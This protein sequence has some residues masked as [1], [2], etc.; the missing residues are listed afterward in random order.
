MSIPEYSKMLTGDMVVLLKARLVPKL[1]GKICT[2]SYYGRLAA[3]FLREELRK[4]GKFAR[5]EWTRGGAM[6]SEYIEIP[7]TPQDAANYT[8]GGCGSFIYGSV[9][10][11]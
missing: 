6:F 9:S 11:S 8:M 5:F 4:T 7:M 3:R 1:V 2:S 10:N